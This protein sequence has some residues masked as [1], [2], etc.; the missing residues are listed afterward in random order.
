MV[1]IKAGLGIFGSHSVADLVDET[2]AYFC[3]NPNKDVFGS[4]LVGSQRCSKRGQLGRHK[5]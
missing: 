3:G 4:V 1:S 2:P 5:K